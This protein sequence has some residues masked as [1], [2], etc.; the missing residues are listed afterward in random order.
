MASLELNLLGDDALL[1]DY[2]EFLNKHKFG[3]SSAI[4]IIELIQEIARDNGFLRLGVMPLHDMNAQEWNEHLDELSSFLKN[5]KRSLVKNQPA[6]RDGKR[7][8]KFLLNMQPEE[9]KQSVNLIIKELFRSETNDFRKL[10]TS[11]LRSSIS[12]LIIQ[13]CRVCPLRIQNW[14][15][16][17]YIEIPSNFEHQEPSLAYHK[18]I[19]RYRIFVPRAYLKNRERADVFDIDMILPRNFN[20]EIERFIKLRRELLAHLHLKEQKLFF[21][22]TFVKE[23]ATIRGYKSNELSSDFKAATKKVIN[24]L[25]AHAMRHLSATEFLN[26]N[27]ENYASLAILLNDSLII[28]LNTYARIDSKLKSQQICE[29]AENKY[30]D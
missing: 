5:L 17:K 23:K 1:A 18:D 27:P 16:L 3:K 26:D 11:T 7:N 24:R 29:W 6:P 30:T 13:L 9:M 14:A 10:A 2:V 15:D 20:T 4:R 8:V 25:N 12:G 28:V 22:V 21:K 19:D